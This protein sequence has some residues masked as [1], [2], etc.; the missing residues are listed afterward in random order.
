MQRF[1][2][3]STQW[4]H[5]PHWGE[6]SVTTWSPG[7]TSVTS[8]ADR[9]DDARALVAEHRRRVAGRVGAGGRVEVGVAD[10]AGD[11]PDQ[12][13]ARAGLGEVELLHDERLPELLEDRGS[14]LHL[15]RHQRAILSL[16]VGERLSV[17][18]LEDGAAVTLPQ[19]VQRRVE[20]GG[21]TPPEGQFELDSAAVPV[22]VRNRDPHKCQPALFDL[23]A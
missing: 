15:G 20:L 18:A 12:H 11:E 6:N 9:L 22:E 16:K 14:H 2:R 21:L 10:A 13:L 1:V 8:V 7:A 3:G 19:C 23:P 4:T 17:R 5:S